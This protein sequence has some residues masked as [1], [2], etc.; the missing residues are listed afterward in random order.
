MS[1]GR[2]LLVSV[3]LLFASCDDPLGTCVAEVS[4]VGAWDYEA[5]PGPSHPYLT[6]GTL[7]VSKES[8]EGFEGRAD[9]LETDGLGAM[10]ARVGAVSGRVLDSGSLRFDV[11]FEAGAR[12]HFGELRTDSMIG[13]FVDEGASGGIVTGDFT[14][15]RRIPS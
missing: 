6:R 11:F 4:L 5:P 15:S 9:L 12:Q 3:C 13:S 2:A 10:R 1:P 14:G 7:T 8:C